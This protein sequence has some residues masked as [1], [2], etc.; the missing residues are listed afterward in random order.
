MVGC[1]I[2]GTCENIL[3]KLMPC[4]LVFGVREK[5]LWGAQNIVEGE[6]HE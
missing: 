1:A 5:A 3:R 6:G 4:H 2:K